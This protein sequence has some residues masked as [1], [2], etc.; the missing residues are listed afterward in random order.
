MFDTTLLI[1]F[2]WY[3]FRQKR[4]QYR[5]SDNNLRGD[6]VFIFRTER[7]ADKTISQPIA[8]REL[9]E[10]AIA[11]TPAPVVIRSHL[12]THQVINLKVFYHEHDYN[13]LHSV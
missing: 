8:Q 6:Q 1:K 7:G 12:S 2:G 5:Y 11:P 3:S 4:L 10:E 9:K 13:L